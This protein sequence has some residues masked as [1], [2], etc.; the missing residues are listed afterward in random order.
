MERLPE[1]FTARPAT[2]DDVAAITAL[3]AACEVADYG[4]SEIT[5]DTMRQV[6]TMP[7]FHPE[8]DLLVVLAP[9]GCVVG[10]AI[11]EQQEYAR[12]Y[13]D[14]V[15]HPE[16]RGL[17]IGSYLTHWGEQI[18]QEWLPKAAPDVRVTLTASAH[19][20][21]ASAKQLLEERGYQLAR[22]FWRMGI[23]LQE[24]PLTPQWPEGIEVRTMAPGQ[25]RAVFA[26]DQDIFQ[27]HWGF[28][29]VKYENWAHW[30]IEREQFDPTLWF[31][32]MDGAA[33]A[34]ISLCGLEE[35]SG[36]WVHD[37][38]VRRPW[39]RKGLALA[40][41][42]HGFG[43]FYKRGQK[44]VYLNVDAQSLT[45]AT[46]LYERAGMH[47]VRQFDRY[48]KELRAGRELSTLSVEV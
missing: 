24:P 9:D 47:V 41:L 11:M 16:Y 38:G 26:A 33:I 13:L 21:N 19:S 17:G 2:L 4:K 40:M 31:L 44:D 27:D 14:S 15:V 5:Q 18:A 36:G 25:E 12:I 6:W 8:H 42:L 34:A 39:R 7:D 28:M 32:A 3:I 10:E 29:P 23:E 1:G 48:E 43:E 35:T 30:S 22:H 20:V 46:K 45:G 37:L